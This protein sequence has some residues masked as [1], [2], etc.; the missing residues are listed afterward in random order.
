MLMLM[1]IAVVSA[2]LA[3]GIGL[4]PLAHA[5]TDQ[6]NQYMISHGEVQG[7]TNCAPAN[8]NCGESLQWLLQQGQNT[9]NA[10]A[11]GKDPG[12]LT[13]QLEHVTSRATAGN[14]VYAAQ[15]YLCP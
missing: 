8:P 2:V 14:I 6:Y 4:A 12:W 10:L 15:H 13:G 3:G 9:C 7:A 11:N 5:D 1:K